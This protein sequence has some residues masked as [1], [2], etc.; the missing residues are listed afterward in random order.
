MSHAI[1]TLSWS[2]VAAVATV[3]VL[4][5][6][7]VARSSPRLSAAQITAG[8]MPLQI[9]ALGDSDTTASGDPTRLGWVGRYARLLRQSLGLR[10]VVSNLAQNG[11]TSSQL[12]AE[13]RSDTTTRAAVKQADI[14][15]LGIGGADLNAGDARWGARKCKDEACYARDLRAFGRNFETT[16]TA[17]R[18]LRSSQRVVL[19]AITLPNALPGAEDVIP[20]FL[21]PVAARIGVYQAEALR[22]AICGSVARHGGRC[23][24]VLHAFNGP[25]GTEN[26]YA[27]GLM[28]HAECCYPS[29][30]GQQLMAELLFKTG[31]KPLR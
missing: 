26:A 5:T 4:L 6:A 10:V 31:L 9:V 29:A 12:L 28:N 27:K 24:D 8:S 7:A 16:V 1:R 25:D 17:I 13:V 19:R 22:R 15:L 30:K 3:A 2:L 20:P 11:R 21:K 23:I 18:H 14:V